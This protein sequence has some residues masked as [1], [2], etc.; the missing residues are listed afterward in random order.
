MVPTEPEHGR[1]RGRRTG[2]RIPCHRTVRSGAGDFSESRSVG[3]LTIATIARWTKVAHT[4]SEAR[5]IGGLDRPT[6]HAFCERC[7]YLNGCFEDFG[8]LAPR[9]TRFVP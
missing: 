1:Q 4:W 2:D 3:V 5:T 6:G 7:T 9:I 8:T